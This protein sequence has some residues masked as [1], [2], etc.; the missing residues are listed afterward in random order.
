MAS[1]FDNTIYIYGNSIYKILILYDM[2][3]IYK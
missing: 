3:H 2:K 1:H